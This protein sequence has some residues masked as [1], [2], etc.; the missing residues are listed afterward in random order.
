[1]ADEEFEMANPNRIILNNER[2]VQTK[3]GIQIIQF[4]NENYNLNCEL[5]L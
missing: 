2:L 1:M 4:T 5:K 3:N